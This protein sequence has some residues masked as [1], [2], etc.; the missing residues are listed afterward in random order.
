MSN[1][2]EMVDAG[3]MRERIRIQRDVG[4][5][6]ASGAIKQDWQ[7]FAEVFA[8]IVPLGGTELFAA[9]QI[10]SESPTTIKLRYIAGLDTAM[11]ILWLDP[12][13]L[14]DVQFDI[15]SIT[16]VE[17]RHYRMELTVI[18]RPLERNA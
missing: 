8:S 12:R 15:K 13:T 2:L 1:L 16:D 3:S 11:R 5:Q 7:D 14:T 10:Y 18:Q 4:A 6:S 9:Q 17:N